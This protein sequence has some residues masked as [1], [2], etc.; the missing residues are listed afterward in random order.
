MIHKGSIE[1]RCVYRLDM[2]EI[3]S[4]MW[5]KVFIQRECSGGENE[6]KLYRHDDIEPLGW[7]E[8]FRLFKRAA[9]VAAPHCEF[10]QTYP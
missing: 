7:G 6:N 8:Q 3:G 9:L 2:L 1:M 5:V 10:G 4:T